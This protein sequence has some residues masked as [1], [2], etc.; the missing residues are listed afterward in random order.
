MAVSQALPQKDY[1]KILGTHKQ[2]FEHEIAECFRKLA[3]TMHPQKVIKQNQAE[4]NSAQ[5]NFIYSEICE[6]YEVLSNP[7]LREIYDKFGENTLKNGFPDGK[8]NFKGGFNFSGDIDGIFMRFFGTRNP[9]TIC[10]DKEDNSAV[11]IES[12]EQLKQK[13]VQ[14]FIS[15]FENIN[16][17]LECSLLELFHGCIKRVIYQ[18]QV[19]L[20]DGT[21][22]KFESVERDIRVKPGMG[23]HS[24]IRFSREGNERKG[25]ITSDVLIL[26]KELPHPVF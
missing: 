10:L 14:N 20:A 9:Q 3:L 4:N 7:N 23:A 15:Q 2:A 21:G 11:Q 1:Y 22:L 16:L 18:R 12:K 13:Y 25:A 8:G 19:L 6:A 5:Y 17:T 26:I 24:V